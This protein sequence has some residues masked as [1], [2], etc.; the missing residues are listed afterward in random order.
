MNRKTAA[1]DLTR[2]NFIGSACCAAVGATGLLSSLANLRLVGAVAT[3]SGPATPPRAGAIASDYKAL[4]CL[5]LNGGN[6][7]NNLIVPVGEGAASDPGSYAAYA[8][9]RSNLALPRTGLLP[10]SP[11]ISDGR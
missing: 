8:A 7:A 2:R 5:F 11:K 6:D 9:A 3:P 4:V 10:I 1:P